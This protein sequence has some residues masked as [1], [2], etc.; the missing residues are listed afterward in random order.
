MTTRSERPAARCYRYDGKQTFGN[1]VNFNP[2]GQVL[3]AGGAF[4]PD[5]RF[6]TLPAVPG[7]LFG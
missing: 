3:A 4:L 6:V 7:S 5:G 2:H 1:L